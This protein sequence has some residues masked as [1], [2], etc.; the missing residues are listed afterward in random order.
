MSIAN[1]ENI[2]NIINYVML[3]AKHRKN[4]SSLNYRLW[5][6]M[7]LY[8]ESIINFSITYRSENNEVKYYLHNDKM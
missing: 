7:I 5:I 8:D 6:A 4:K 2:K 1:E 3:E